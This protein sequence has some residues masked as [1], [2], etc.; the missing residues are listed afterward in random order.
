VRVLYDAMGSPNV[1]RKF[2]APL[3]E[4]GGE[5]IAFNPVRLLRITFGNFRTHRK[6]A[7]CDGLAG[8]L[9]GI[10]MHEPASAT[11][12]GKNAWRDQHVRIDGEPVHRIQRLFLEN[13]NYSRGE[14]KLN[15]ANVEKYF[16]PARIGKG[17]Y[18][19]ELLAAIDKAMQ[20]RT[21][22]R[23]QTAS[24]LQAAMRLSP[25]APRQ[26]EMPDDSA[27]AEITDIGA[28]RSA[29]SRRAGDR[30]Q[31]RRFEAVTAASNTTASRCAVDQVFEYG[32][33][34]HAKTI[35]IDDTVGIVGPRHRQPL[36]PPEFRGGSGVLR[37]K[38]HRAA[39]QALRR[40]GRPAPSRSAP[41]D[42]DRALRVDRA[43][44]SP[45]L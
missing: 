17:K 9:G 5:V 25:V 38:Y 40:I 6:I 34:M 27:A 36:L 44:T 37:S 11:R 21:R 22:D 1:N 32:P 42:G 20:F 35:V 7:I 2:W 8:F 33:P 18:S 39:R 41:R 24:E 30:P 28:H 29:G 31:A 15:A 19:D 4:A 12:S 14:F 45:V 10:N 3:R 43:A 23:P 26:I 13:W 16:P